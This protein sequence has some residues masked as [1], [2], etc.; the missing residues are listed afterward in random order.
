M[1]R[2]LIRIGVVLALVASVVVARN[3]V[4]K[5][6]PLDVR[7][8]AAARGQVEETVTNT[9]AGTI[10]ALRRAQISPEVGGWAVEVPRREGERVEKGDVLL[11]LDPTVLDAQ[12]TLSRRDLQAAR[13][14]REQACANAERSRRELARIS[15]LAKDGIISADALDQAQTAAATTE[16]ACRGIRW[17]PRS[18][19][20]RSRRARRSGSLRDP[21]REDLPHLSARRPAGP[22][23]RGHRRARRDWGARSHHGPSGSGKSTLLYTLGCLDRPDSGAYWLGGRE[24]A[25]LNDE[26]LTQ[27]RRHLI[28]F[29][30]QSFHLVPRLTA[31]GNVDLPMVFAGL[32]RGE[33]REKVEAALAAVGL[34]DRIDHRP[35]QLS[36][37]ER[38]RVALARAMVMQPRLLLADEPTGNLDTSSGRQILDLLD[39]MNEAGTTL[40]VVTHDPTVAQRADRVIVLVDGRIV[41]RLPGRDVMG[42]ANLFAPAEPEPG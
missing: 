22:R 27:I 10:K 28:G 3:T 7:A 20:R 34:A 12:L 11:R 21:P 30:F 32:P 5:P 31:A 1:R 2:W 14:Q 41:R 6:D 15:R 4:L 23:P 29:V 42:A 19:S 24:V 25:R 18:T 39:R 37:G 26:E 17:S 36:G 38:Q 33:R 40:V 9:R 13:A 8:A 16:S 35:D